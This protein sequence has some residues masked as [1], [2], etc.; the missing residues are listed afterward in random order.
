MK[1]I[2]FLLFSFNLLA[3]PY[4]VIQEQSYLIIKGTS[5]LHDWE[6]KGPITEGDANF[7]IQDNQL[8]DIALLNLRINV[9]DLKSDSE[10]LN[11]NAYRA[12]HSKKFPKIIFQFKELESIKDKIVT[13]KGEFEVS[14]IKKT[15]VIQGNLPYVG[16]D[17]LKVEGDYKVKMT[18]FKIEPPSVM[19][20]MVRSGDEIELKYQ[21]LFKE[22]K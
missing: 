16:E 4:R 2:L 14:G 7:T 15:V 12:L 22:N 19:L 3:S 8:R 18:E 21:I 9:E 6:M 11:E 10:G 20:G 5:T 1:Y 13:L 17:L